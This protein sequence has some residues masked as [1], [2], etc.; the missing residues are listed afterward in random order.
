MV[1]CS[2]AVHGLQGELVTLH[3]PRIERKNIRSTEMFAARVRTGTS[4]SFFI[5]GLVL[6]RAPLSFMLR[7]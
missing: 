4:E 3:G 6:G 1:G 7:I 5:S 2:G